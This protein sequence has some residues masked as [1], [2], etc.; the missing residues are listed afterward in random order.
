MIAAAA[1]LL[2]ESGPAALTS[3][4]VA[5]RIGVT[6]S[7]IYRHVSDMD[8]LV[9]LAGQRVVGE[10]SAVLTSAATSPET[11]WGGGD[12]LVRFAAR[13]VDIVAE[14]AQAV[15]TVDRWRHEPDALGEGIQ[16]FLD[17]GAQIVAGMLEN[18]WRSDFDH[19]DPF[20]EVTAAVQL[21]HARLAL[22]DMIA[23][24]RDLHGAGPAATSVIARTLSFRLFAAWCGYV[25]EMNTR[26][27]LPIPELGGPT[28]SAPE[29]SLP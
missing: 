10:L 25:L 26:L 12:D 13:M 17:A 20:D 9:T 1:D 2:R 15:T 19:H 11:T 3:V 22:D 5:K 6:Q 27:G 21:A 16:T 18:S 7:A 29:Y 23:V 24:T 8:E 28:M 4:E 14:H